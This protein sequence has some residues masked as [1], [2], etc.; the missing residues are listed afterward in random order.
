MHDIKAAVRWLRANAARHRLDP[1][2]RL[3]R[4]TFHQTV[5]ATRATGLRWR[6]PA[7][8]AIGPPPGDPD[9]P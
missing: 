7:T 8:D 4:N 5:D 9:P 3:R 1:D 2:R 6:T